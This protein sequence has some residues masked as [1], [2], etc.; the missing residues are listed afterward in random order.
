MTCCICGRFSWF[1]ASGPLI[2]NLLLDVNKLAVKGNCTIC[3]NMPVF[4]VSRCWTWILVAN[5]LLNKL[6]LI[7]CSSWNADETLTVDPTFIYLQWWM[8][9]HPH[10][11]QRIWGGWTWIYKGK[12]LVLSLTHVDLSEVMR[13]LAPVCMGDSKKVKFPLPYKGLQSLSYLSYLMGIF[14]RCCCCCCD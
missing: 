6:W 2:L 11:W 8:T 13:R 4:A 9:G 1:E 12:Q 5:G 10:W 7:S 3:I 14:S